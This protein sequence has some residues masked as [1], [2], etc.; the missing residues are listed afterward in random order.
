[1]L[2]NAA[3]V[4]YSIPFPILTV[5]SAVQ[6]SK[7]S[8]H[9]SVTLSGITT[10]VIALQSE[11]ANAVI[12]ST[13]SGIIISPPHFL[14]SIKTLFTITSGFS[15]RLFSSHG[16]PSN[17]QPIISCT[18]SGMVTDSSEVQP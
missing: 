10:D 4:I 2:K 13:P 6:L 9:I 5:S 1:M 18:F 17:A 3:A 16:V 11:K 7:A 8:A 14:P 15:L 12:F